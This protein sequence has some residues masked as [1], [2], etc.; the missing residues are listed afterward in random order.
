MCS[1]AEPPKLP[2]CSTK[3]YLNVVVVVPKEALQKYQQA[4]V[5]KEFMN[6]EEEEF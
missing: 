2:E 4:P 6:L 3:Q 5:W 1:Q